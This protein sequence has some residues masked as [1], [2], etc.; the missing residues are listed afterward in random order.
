MMAGS[1]NRWVVVAFVLAVSAGP[2]VKDATAGK[3]PKLVARVNNKGFRAS[4]R[5]SI[6]GAYTAAGVTLTG[7]SAHVGR[8]GGTIKTLTI[9]CAVPI[10]TTTF[11]VT[12][13]C[14][15]AYTDNTFRGLV[16]PTNPKGW[17]AGSGLQVTFQS[18]DGTRVKGTFEGTLPPGD[19][20]PTD[21]PANFQHGKF[22]MDLLNGGA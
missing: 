8:R 18:F 20:N 21:P 11:P 3:K 22:S 10:T 4:L 6:V 15:G 16:Q 12:V 5:A 2:A 9:S 17:A 7:L 13:D 1:R 19:S 14:A